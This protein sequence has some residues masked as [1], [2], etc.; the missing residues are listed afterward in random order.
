MK[1][2]IIFLFL[3][4]ITLLTSCQEQNFTKKEATYSAKNNISIDVESREINISNSKDDKIYINYYDS[5]KEFLTITE[6]ENA[7]NIKLDTNKEWTDFIGTQADLSYRKIEIQIPNSLI[8]KLVITTTNE[9]V[10][11]NSINI[12]NINVSATDGNINFT[13]LATKNIYL[14]VKNANIEGSILGK[15]ADYKVE[16]ELKK[17]DTN[18]PSYKKDGD[19]L[20]KVNGNNGNIF[21]DF[22]ND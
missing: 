11:L 9:N 19:N 4:L 1:K 10:N 7:L 21:I 12:D 22:L 5:E 3:F 14:T 8:N 2:T 6:D 18:L 20:L 17:G 13:S 15:M 16:L